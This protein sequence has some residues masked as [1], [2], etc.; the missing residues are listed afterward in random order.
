MLKTGVTNHAALAAYQHSDRKATLSLVFPL[1][2]A[3]L[4]Y[5][6]S[7]RNLFREDN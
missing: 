7:L 3:G 5:G 4:V 2:F 1:H 6:E